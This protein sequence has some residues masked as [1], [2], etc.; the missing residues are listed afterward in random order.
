MLVGWDVNSRTRMLYGESADDAPHELGDLLNS[1]VSRRRGLHAWILDWDFAMVYAL[2][3]EVFPLFR[4]GGKSHRR[5]HFR[6]DSQ[7]PVGASQHQK[8]V[9]VDGKVAFVGGMDVT[10]ARWDT[11]RHLPGDP[12]RVDPWRRKYDPYH[13]VQ[14]V[15]D[16]EAAAAVGELARERWYRAT[17]RRLAPVTTGND[18]WPLAVEP[19][20]ERVRVGIARTEPEFSGRPKIREVESSYLDSIAAAKQTIYIENQYLTASA[21]GDALAKRLE[22][23]GGPEIVVVTTHS[24]HGWLEETTMGVLRARL[25]ERLREADHERRLRLYSPRAAVDTDITVHAKLMIVDDAIVRVGSANLNN[26]S[27]GLDSECDVVIESDGK[28]DVASAIAAFRN[29][30]VAEHLVTEPETVARAVDEHGSLGA[31]IETLR[32]G[33]HTLVPLHVE[34]GSWLEAVAPAAGVLDPERPVQVEDLIEQLVPAEIEGRGPL[35]RTV[36]TATI[37]AAVVAAWYWTPVSDWLQAQD[38]WAWFDPLRESPIGPPAAV[39]TI[40]LGA[41]VMAPITVLTALAGFI[42]GPWLGF[43]TALAGALAS[44][45]LGYFVGKHARRDTVQRVAGRSLN[46]LSRSL[47]SGGMRS[48]LAVRFLPMASFGA[49]N[50]VA[51]ASRVRYRQFFLGTVLAMAPGTLA[52]AVLGHQAA[53][54]VRE[55]RSSTLVGAALLGAALV[56]GVLAMRRHLARSAPARGSGG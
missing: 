31:A 46:R 17:G 4:F 12:R 5:V 7:H 26:R 54:A 38:I 20:L 19:E 34:T 42:F 14:A 49:V 25:V 2:D 29:R 24:C 39:A 32:G 44:A 53:N 9:V 28:A 47:G 37:V 50:L 15:F 48:I 18:P 56:A 16:G 36:L 8:I 27:M 21:V 45:T 6:L 55:A 41:L 10:H 22:E 30:L 11:S 35:A 40:A 51:G 43:A 23:P 13:D 3:R 33:E 1:A 52:L